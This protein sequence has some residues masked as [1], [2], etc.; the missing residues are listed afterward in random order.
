MY[1]HT[2][3]SIA[4]V[5][6][7]PWNIRFFYLSLIYSLDCFH[8]SSSTKEKNNRRKRPGKIFIQLF[9]ECASLVGVCRTTCTS[10]FLLPG[11]FP[12]FPFRH[13]QF[14]SFFFP[15]KNSTTCLS[16]LSVIADTV[17]THRK[18]E[19]EKKRKSFLSQTLCIYLD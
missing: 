6:V 4:I 11:H 9:R 2:H 16:F 18:E 5:Y 1:T 8:C 15:S 14:L 13:F 19:R 10:H 3:T 17:Q 12:S 7:S